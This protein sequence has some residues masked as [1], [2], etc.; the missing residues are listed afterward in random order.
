[1]EVLLVVVLAGIIA[2][3]ALPMVGNTQS[4][5]LAAAARLLMADIGFAQADSISHPD[6]PCVIV[7]DTA[8]NSY[9]LTRA[10]D[11][12]TAITNPADGQPY[13]TQLG[14]GRAAGATGVTLQGYSL[15]GD[16]KLGF[17]AYGQLDQATQATVT[18]QA[19]TYTITVQVDPT[20]GETSTSGG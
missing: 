3:M 20:S 5:R 1:V 14:L 17:G 13:Q 6:D 19:G 8:A 4:T 11:T 18:F 16:N 2:V 15:N 9:K 12:A 10:S 7:F